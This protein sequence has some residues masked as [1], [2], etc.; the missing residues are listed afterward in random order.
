VIFGG[1]GAKTTV[2]V[3][4]H[5]AYDREYPHPLFESVEPCLHIRA[6]EQGDTQWIR[7]ASELAAT[8][9]GRESPGGPVHPGPGGPRGHAQRC[10]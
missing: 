2:L 6:L 1:E 3:C 7:Q 4:G 10:G 5:L 9:S 8:V